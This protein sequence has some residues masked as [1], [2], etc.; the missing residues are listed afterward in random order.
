MKNHGICFRCNG[1]GKDKHRN[2]CKRCGG[3]GLYERKPKL[4]RFC[5]S[6]GMLD[7]RKVARM[8][9][10]QLAEGAVDVIRYSSKKMCGHLEGAAKG[11]GGAILALARIIDRIRGYDPDQK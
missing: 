11:F 4:L 5:Q 1:T 2:P 9:N 6:C 10:G 3:T 8:S 7:Q